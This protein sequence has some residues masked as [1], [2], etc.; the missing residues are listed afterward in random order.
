MTPSAAV[1]NG[2]QMCTLP[3]GGGGGSVLT[4][5]LVSQR[6]LLLLQQASTSNNT[7]TS[8]SGGG[9]VAGR[10]RLFQTYDMKL[11]VTFMMNCPYLLR[12]G[13]PGAC[14]S[15]GGGTGGGGGGSPKPFSAGLYVWRQQQ[16]GLLNLVR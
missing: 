8:S 15:S 16:A 9:T 14:D 1:T 11:Y 2:L 7:T 3:G 4:L 10:V 6:S 12:S 5:P 13:N